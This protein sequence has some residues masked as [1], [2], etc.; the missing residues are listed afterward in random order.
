MIFGYLLQSATDLTQKSK[1]LKYRKEHTDITS[2]FACDRITFEQY[3]LDQFSKSFS[4]RPQI[5]SACKQFH[6]E[7]VELLYQWKVVCVDYLFTQATF[8]RP[9]HVPVLVMNIKF[10]SVLGQPTVSNALTSYPSLS[11]VKHWHINVH[12]D[13]YGIRPPHSPPHGQPR[14]NKRHERCAKLAACQSCVNH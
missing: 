5:L 9:Q 12:F 2:A 3:E 11:K 1:Y 8:E 4:L 14:D 7:G 6:Y 10:G 13:H